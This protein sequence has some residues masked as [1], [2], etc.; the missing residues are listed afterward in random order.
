MTNSIRENLDKGDIISEISLTID[1]PNGKDIKCVVVEGID[2]IRALRKFFLSDVLL[3]ESFSGKDGLCEI[4]D[5]FN[6][7]IYF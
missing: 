2:D 6:N 5:Y 3:F 1:Y 4:V 7:L